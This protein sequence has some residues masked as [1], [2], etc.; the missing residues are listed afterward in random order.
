MV[1][2]AAGAKA[3]NEGRVQVVAPWLGVAAE[4]VAGGG[5]ITLRDAASGAEVRLSPH[6]FEGRAGRVLRFRVPVG[7]VID[8][9]GVRW[10][11]YYEVACPDED[12]AATLGARIEEMVGDLFPRTFRLRQA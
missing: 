7:H 2:E 6:A 3:R 5:V 10:D 12:T 1:G 9:A 11:G 8:F 4:C